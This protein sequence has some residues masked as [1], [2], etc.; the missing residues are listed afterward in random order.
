[1]KQA[2]TILA[3]LAALSGGCKKK[4][5]DACKAGQSMCIDKSS[6]LYC[7]DGKFAV[8]TCRG[9]DGCKAANGEI[10]CDNKAA[11]END[12]CD[13]E[14]DLAC[15][16]DKRNELRCHANKFTVAST[17]RGSKGCW[18]EGNTLHCDTDLAEPGDPCE[19]AD[20]IA[21]AVDQ[22]SELKCR[23]GRFTIENT[24]KGPKGCTVTGTTLHCDDDLADLGD[25]CKKDGD[26]ACSMDKKALLI[27]RGS[28]FV[29]E[30]ACKGK[31]CSYAEHGDK[32]NFECH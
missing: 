2:A 5:G 7:Q 32:I 27:C 17:C 9:A 26:Y 8:Q 12:G 23:S 3:L 16:L 1:M 13:E 4:A 11:L 6:A 31:G 20:D 19:D 10:A 30:Q 25:A 18:F 29:Q 15:T 22:K 24:C 21:C 14:K 28:K